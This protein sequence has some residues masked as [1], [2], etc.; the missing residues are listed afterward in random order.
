MRGCPNSINAIVQKQ[1]RAFAGAQMLRL[2]SF[3][4]IVIIDTTD[5]AAEK[6]KKEWH[7]PLTKREVCASPDSNGP[8]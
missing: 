3:E 1:P 2:T 8:I 5:T 4:P 6:A 7:L